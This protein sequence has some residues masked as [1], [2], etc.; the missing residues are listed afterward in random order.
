MLGISQDAWNCAVDALGEKMTAVAV[1]FILQRSEHSSEA[2]KYTSP[3]DGSIKISVCGSPA[4]RS[5][6]GYL[7]ALTEK[8]REGEFSLWPALLAHL[9]Q[10]AKRGKSE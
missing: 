6:G 10:R 5:P 2:R 7:R 1:A 4:I 8:A 3:A 9:S